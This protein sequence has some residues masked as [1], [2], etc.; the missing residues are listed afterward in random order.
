MFPKK[1]YRASAAGLVA[2]VAVLLMGV[3]ATDA[4]SSAPAPV[5]VRDATQAVNVTSTDCSSDL[6][7]RSDVVC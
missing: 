1:D 7:C 6:Q 4:L 2:A 3:V 5:S